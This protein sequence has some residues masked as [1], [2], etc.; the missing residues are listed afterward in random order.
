MDEPDSGREVVI[1]APDSSTG[2]SPATDRERDRRCGYP[3]GATACMRFLR[4]I[5]YLPQLLRHTVVAGWHDRV[6]GLSAEAA[7][8]QLLSLPSLFLAS[9]ASLGYVSRWLGTGT[10]DRTE[11]QIEATLARAFSPEVVN[12][13]VSPTLREI[14]HGQ[15][16]DIISVGFA[17]ALWAG[18]SAT[19][20]F[21]NTITI[22][23]GMRDQRGAVQS[24]LLALGLFLGSIA[25]G[26]VL[27]PLLVL[28]PSLV[29]DLFPVGIRA[30]AKSFITD[31][32][33][34]MVVLLILLGLTTLYHLAPP[35]R[36]PWG[37]GVPGACLA[38]GIF[39]FGSIALRTYITFILDQNH[40]YGALAAPI[41]A[42]LFFY[43]LALGVLLGAE[44][45][46][47]IEQLSPTLLG[48]E[49]A[50]SRWHRLS[51][52]LTPP[53]AV[54][55]TAAEASATE[56]SATGADSPDPDAAEPGEGYSPPG[57][58]S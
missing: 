27:L 42:L 53:A 30:G 43:V 31:A 7:F 48:R 33:Y 41:A 45:N 13:V 15:R 34:P 25:V 56:A 21:V 20:T 22:A 12:E 23:Y 38:L 10:V 3:N 14:L 17:L 2:L 39:L 5:R 47:A 35:R 19:A 24:R 8:W 52:E 16:I 54:S 58:E 49:A 28:G 37:R 55:E 1:A 29:G 26:V 51:E 44:F 4:R 6:L 40:A 46:A 36:L 32:Y 11:S 57:S 50:Q 18:S 9:I